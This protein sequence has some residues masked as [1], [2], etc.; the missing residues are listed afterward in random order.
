MTTR[1]A[2]VSQEYGSGLADYYT[3][4]GFANRVNYGNRPAILV[5]DMANAFTDGSYMLGADMG[6][7]VE[8]IAGLLETAR[9]NSVPIVYTTTSFGNPPSEIGLAGVK[10]P[11]LAELKAGT[12]AV[13]IDSRLAP[14]EGEFVLVKKYWS[15][16]M[17]T[18]LLPILV[19]KQVD[20]LV[21]T[22]NSTSGC[23]R[24]AATDALCYGFR[25]II[26]IEAVGDRFDGPHRSNLFDINAKFGDVQPVA[27]VGRYLESDHAWKRV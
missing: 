23:V 2:D 14:Q 22:G 26:P 7:V 1:Q 21:I 4:H 17:M 6:T 8:A 15:S 19:Y 5:V 9:A 12:R 3:N 13:E 24:A 10:I 25:P 20:T 11:S 16:F 18:N 27:A